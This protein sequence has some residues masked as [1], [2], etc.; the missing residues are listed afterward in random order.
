MILKEIIK[1]IFGKLLL[2][3]FLILSAG[4]L[5]K[6]GIDFSTGTYSHTGLRFRAGAFLLPTV[7]M[8]VFIYSWV[9]LPKIHIPV[10]ES[11]SINDTDQ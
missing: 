2:I 9:T 7:L 5:V 8:V 11:P 4:I 1:K 6:T 3:L 10:P